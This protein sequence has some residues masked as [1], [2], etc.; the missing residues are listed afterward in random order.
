MWPILLT[1]SD[2]CYEGFDSLKA[3]RKT[4]CLYVLYFG[5]LLISSIF[6]WKIEKYEE[7]DID[8]MWSI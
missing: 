6:S 8:Q 7:I 5:S 4:S 3:V 2:Y 1:P